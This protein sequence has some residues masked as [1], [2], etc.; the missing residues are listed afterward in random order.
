MERENLRKLEEYECLP[1][2][3]TGRVKNTW[4]IK[5]TAKTSEWGEPKKECSENAMTALNN[6]RGIIERK[7]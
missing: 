6:I 1:R 5:K 7:D 3:N 4:S 2:E